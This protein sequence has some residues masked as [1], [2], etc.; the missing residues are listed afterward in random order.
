MAIIATIVVGRTYGARA[1]IKAAKPVRLW[2]G[3]VQWA[4][5]LRLTVLRP[6]G[7]VFE[8][9]VK[10]YATGTLRALAMRSSFLKEGAFLPRS[11]KLRKSTDMPIISAKSS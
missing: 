3:E 8:S 9:K 10:R 1:S 11:I 2:G 6:R 7:A 4:R 5:R